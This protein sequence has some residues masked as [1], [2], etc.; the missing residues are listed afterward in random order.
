M[1]S[2]QWVMFKEQYKNYIIKKYNV[3]DMTKFE[4]YIKIDMLSVFEEE[5]MVGTN[6]LKGAFN[7]LKNFNYTRNNDL[8]KDIDVSLIKESIPEYIQELITKISISKN[9]IYKYK[10]EKIE[11]LKI[12][13]SGY[14]GSRITIHV[15][16]DFNVKMKVHIDVAIEE[17]NGTDGIEQEN[18]RKYYS[19]TRTLA[20]KYV[21][22]IQRNDS[23]TREKDFIDLSA[24]WNHVDLELFI[25]LSRRLLANR[26]ISKEEIDLFVES[27]M[28]NPM[29][30]KH[31]LLKTI[32]LINSKVL[33]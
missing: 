8:T 33:N 20:D 28:D 12:D 26:E 9:D 3:K 2:L 24:L 1:H 21:T 5:I 7:L 13:V 25:D 10:I 17:I 23:N 32:K 22:M 27:F 4:S 16:T 6:I 18:G 29:I 15:S 14:S 11:E 19:I 31:D 30:I